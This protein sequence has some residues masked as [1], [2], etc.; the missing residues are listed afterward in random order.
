MYYIYRTTSKLPDISEITNTVEKINEIYFVIKRYVEETRGMERSERIRY[1][2]T[3][4][5]A[6][7]NN[8]NIDYVMNTVET[9][10]NMEE[11]E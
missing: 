5:H 1:I 6:D 11:K 4:V 2:V 7:Y 8:V 3:V 9:L 10:L